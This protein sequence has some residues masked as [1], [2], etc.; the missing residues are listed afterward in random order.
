MTLSKFVDKLPTIKTIKPTGKIDGADYYQIRIQQFKQKLHRD[1][2]KTTVWGFE[3]NYPGPTIEVKMNELIKVKWIN[4][5]PEKHLLPVDTTVHGAE[6]NKPRVRTVIHLHGGVVRPD[7]D[8]YPDAWYT[9]EYKEVGPAFTRKIYD[10]PNRQRGTT[11]WYHAHAIGITRLNVYAGI[12]GAYIIRDPFEEWF[13]LPKGRYEKLLFI[14]DRSFND[15]GSYYYPTEPKPPVPDVYPS[16]VPDFFGENI[17]VNGKV[18]PYLEVEPRKYRFRIINGSNSRFYRMRFS[19][20]QPFYQIGTDG[21]L[22]SS[23]VITSQIL[24]APAE[25]ADVI[26]DF[27][28]FMGQSIVMTNDAPSPYP[29]GNPVDL[30]TDGQIMQFRVSLPLSGCDF[31]NIPYKLSTIMPLHENHAR[32]VRNL[33]LVRETDKYNRAFLLL[34]GKR[35][36]DPITIKPKLGSI[37][38]WNLINLANSTHPIHIHLV[39]FQILRRQPFDVEYYKKTGK[40]LVTGQAV[41]PEL[42]E[43]GWKD[44]V[45]ANPGEITTIIMRFA[46]Y[47]GLYPWHCHILEHEDHE[48]MRPYEIIH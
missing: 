23:P 6:A 46:P 31:S 38:V 30:D 37:E 14:Q 1:L 28:R 36:D 41:L 29:R 24:L 20:G 27:T 26:V 18:W 13:N 33:T 47:S 11:L 10:Y 39:N 15:D 44:T 21:G 25:R 4:D 3:G 19:S 16:V 9:K 45:R 2:D 40:I 34:D 7:S 22:L 43:R 32:L 48:M 12:A 8:G 17:L 5:L 35:W 42:N